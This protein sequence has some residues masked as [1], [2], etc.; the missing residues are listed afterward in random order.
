VEDLQANQK[1]TNY[2]G[3]AIDGNVSFPLQ[4]KVRHL[5]L[6][7]VWTSEMKSMV[8]EEVM[9]KVKSMLE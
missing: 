9:K 1:F 8:P 3:S 6:E 2:P 4:G 5:M 7:K